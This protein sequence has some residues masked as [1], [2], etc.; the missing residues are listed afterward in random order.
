ME[1][2]DGESLRKRLSRRKRMPWQELLPF[3]DQVCQVLEAMHRKGIIH[4]DLKPDNIFFHK[5]EDQ[6]IVKVLDFG[7]A[8]MSSTATHIEGKLTSTGALIGTPHYMSPEQCQGMDLDSRSD[9]YSL[10][11]IL[12]EMLAGQLPFEAENT[13]SM[14]FKHVRETPPPLYQKC[15]DVPPAISDV[16]LRALAKNPQKRFASAKELHQALQEAAQSPNSGESQYQAEPVEDESEYFQSELPDL[17]TKEYD[18]GL[19]SPMRPNQGKKGKAKAALSADEIAKM[20]TQL[21]GAAIKVS[22]PSSPI[23]YILPVV[24][25]AGLAVGGYF[26]KMHNTETPPIVAPNV[27]NKPAV[28]N[29]PLGKLKDSFV[30][31]PGGQFAIGTD[32]KNCPSVPDCKITDDEKPEHTV[33]LTAYYLSKYE[34]TN[35]EYQEFVIATKHQPPKIW[36]GND[37]PIG[38]DDL[39]VTYVSWDDAVAYCQWRSQRDGLDFRLPTEAEWEHAERGKDA[40]IFPWGDNWDN[41]LANANKTT[42][43]IKSPLA[44]NKPPNNTEDRSPFGIYAMAGNVS[45]WTATDFQAYPGSN[46]KPTSKDLTCKVVRGGSFNTSPNTLRTT[47]RA[48]YFPDKV[49]N[50]LGFRLAITPPA[51]GAEKTN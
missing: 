21:T 36:N 19:T 50:D 40:R 25:L 15:A 9:L 45:E 17:S 29:S 13:L 51:N 33:N 31:I 44:I 1:Y 42:A 23:K 20:P 10:G 47:I 3:A 18:S 38:A 43:D 5:Q 2:L 48:W 7:I 39:P 28:D 32:M 27:I 49:N 34:L 22:P 24:I 35:R 14:L 37:F 8:K 16:I 46:F 11:I 41:S 12:Y 30:L 4:R 26:W 6:E